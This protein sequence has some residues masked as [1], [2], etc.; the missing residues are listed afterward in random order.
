MIVAGY[1]A[2]TGEMTCIKRLCTQM[3][4]RESSVDL[5]AHRMIVLK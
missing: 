3:F 4:S 1:A 2:R 5:D